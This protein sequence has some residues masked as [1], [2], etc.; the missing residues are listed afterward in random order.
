MKMPIFLTKEFETEV[1]G[2]GEGF[3]CIIQ[4]DI[5]GQETRIALSVHQF[6]T[7]FNHEKTLV[8]EAL[9]DVAP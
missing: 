1:F 4:K 6:E 9:N 7:I 8:R 5:D 3:I 2:T